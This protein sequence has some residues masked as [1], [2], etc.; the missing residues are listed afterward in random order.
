MKKIGLLSDTHGAWPKEAYDFFGHCNE[1][2]HAG[3]IGSTLLADEISAFKPLR[4]VYGN[5]DSH[6]IR[7]RFPE[8]NIF[9]VE[10]VKVVML[11]IGG[12]PGR[13]E[14]KAREAILTE[15]PKLFITGHSHILK[16]IFDPKLN[17]LHLNP[18]AAG[19]SGLHQVITMLR[20]EINGDKIGNLEIFEKERPGGRRV[21]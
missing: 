18:G 8:I 10:Q 11:H 20:F 5:I 17:V 12:Y 6:E 14:K 16:V 19:N 21:M 4:A 15:N 7:Y 1:I 2:W 13:Y 9:E 3:D